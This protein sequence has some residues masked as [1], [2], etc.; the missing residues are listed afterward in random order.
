ML[1]CNQCRTIA[2]TRVAPKSGPRGGPNLLS[3]SRDRRL[4]QSTNA[5]PEV[6]DGPMNASRRSAINPPLKPR[7]DR[8]PAFGPP[9]CPP[10]SRDGPGGL[11]YLLRRSR[12]LRLPGPLCPDLAGEGAVEVDPHA[13]IEY[14]LKPLNLR[15]RSRGEAI[16]RPY[17]PY[18]TVA[19]SPLRLWD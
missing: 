6:I 15:P 9:L 19:D 13:E 1:G 10:P 17:T 4:P 8:P 11:S 3:S 7:T 16:T 12:S 18:A 2:E 14:P 5:V